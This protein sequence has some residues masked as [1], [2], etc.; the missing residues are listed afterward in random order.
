[1]IGSS[2]S[3]AS[4][5]GSNRTDADHARDP[6]GGSTLVS[7]TGG[8]ASDV[9]VI[10]GEGAMCSMLV[11]GTCTDGVWM[12]GLAGVLVNPNRPVSDV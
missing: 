9:D 8:C 11:N 3:P 4:V 6:L 2:Q 12:E 1:M 7:G 10:G 5:D